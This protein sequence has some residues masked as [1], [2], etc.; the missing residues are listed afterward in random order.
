ML[1]GQAQSFYAEVPDSI[2]RPY[3]E[4]SRATP[5]RVWREVIGVLVSED[6][7]VQLAKWTPR[8]LLIVPERDKVLGERP[9]QILADAMPGAHLAR[10]ART[11]HA[12]H[13]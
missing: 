4:A 9:M 5:G 6:T 2:V 13:W 1:A 7:R 11:S 10:L 3:I 8:T 12:P